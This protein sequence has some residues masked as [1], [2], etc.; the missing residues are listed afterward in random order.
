MTNVRGFSLIEAMITITILSILAAIAIPSYQY[1]MMKSR[2]A[3]AKIALT[4]LAQAQET[5]YIDR[6]TYALNLN[7]TT[8]ADTIRC[9]SF[10]KMEGT[11]A[12][13]PDGYYALDI[14]PRGGG[15]IA[16]G[17]VLKATARGRQLKDTECQIF[18]LDS[19]NNKGPNE[20]CW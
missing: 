3:D 19:I 16:T 12:V 9:Q 14:A 6:R 13:S 4:E 5:F 11:Q 10:C 15:T 17:F 8:S 20:H 7:T 18:T 1:A 2:R